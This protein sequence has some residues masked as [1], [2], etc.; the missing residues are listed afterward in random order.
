[1]FIARI[2]LWRDFPSSLLLFC[3]LSRSECRASSVHS[4]N[5]GRE[6]GWKIDK[7]RIERKRT[8]NGKNIYWI[9][10]HTEF[11]GGKGRKA[12]LHPSE[13]EAIAR[14]DRNENYILF[15]FHHIFPHF[16]SDIIWRRAPQV[17][18]ESR[19]N[20][21]YSSSSPPSHRCARGREV[22]MDG[23]K[24]VEN[25]FFFGENETFFVVSSRAEG[26]GGSWKN[27]R[28]RLF[29]LESF[30]R[31]RVEVAFDEHTIFQLMKTKK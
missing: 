1:M 10:E 2:R 19:W 13:R 5:G 21:I 7:K 15:I 4:P 20:E 24:K 8:M 23:M 3:L 27:W 29:F 28:R 22:E 14:G 25:V 30:W 18:R 31:R 17:S 16:P 26:G 12:K 9:A 11:F 6:C